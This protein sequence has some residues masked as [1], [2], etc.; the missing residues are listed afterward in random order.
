MSTYY[1][2]DPLAEFTDQELFDTIPFMDREL[3]EAMF[4]WRPRIRELYLQS[5]ILRVRALIRDQVPAGD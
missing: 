4:A 1:Q 5:L 3:R 2:G